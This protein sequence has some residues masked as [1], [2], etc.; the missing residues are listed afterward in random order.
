[1]NNAANNT[2]THRNIIAGDLVLTDHDFIAR[3]EYIIE[4][5]AGL[6]DRTN[7]NRCEWPL[8]RLTRL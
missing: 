8:D 7:G 4:D 3:V 2:N 6:V 1:M 5:W